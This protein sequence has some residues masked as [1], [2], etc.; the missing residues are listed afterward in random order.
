MTDGRPPLWLDGTSLSARDV[1]AV[2]RTLGPTDV[3]LDRAALAHVARAARLGADLSTRR[4][5]YGRTTGVG[6]NRDEHVGDDA[7]PADSA[8]S[9]GLSGS[10]G[11]TGSAGSA[12]LTGSAGHGLRL[13]RSH[14]GGAGDQLDPELVRAAML[15]RLN[16]LLTG[17]SGVSPGLVHALADAVRTGARPVVH[18]LGAIGTGDLAPLAQI[19][20]ALAGEGAWDTA[21]PVPEPVAVDAG[22][23]LAFV[24]SNAVTLAESALAAGTLDV[25]LASSHVVAALSYLALDGSPEA[26]ADPVHRAR[27][28]PGQ[29]RC[30]QR[31]RHLL[32]MERT[33]PKG[34]RIQ[35]P[36]GLRA[37]PQVNGPAIDAL[38]TLHRVLDVEINA[39]AENPMI[40]VA[41]DDVYHHAHFHTAY[42]AGALDHV[43]A[44]IH[45]VA[46][47]SAARLG[48][49]VE[50][51][52]TGLRAFL[53]DG[54]PGSSGVMILEYMSHDALAALRQVAL[55]VTLGSAVVSRG[56]ED[57]ASF[58]TQAA[59]ATTEVA[60]AYTR[61]LACE[62]VAAVR[63]LRLRRQ[64]AGVPAAGTGPAPVEEAL[65]RAEE[66]LDPRTEDRPLADD[67]AVAVDLLLDPTWALV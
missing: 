48:D 37:F 33:P 31:M 44:C 67:V 13:L 10:A 40:A 22:D 52:Q 63:A 1:A 51:E 27:P 16:Q 47:L 58:S 20:L 66:V 60:I 26:Y 43:R 29:V 3:H 21:P 19:A 7:E 36:F 11:L 15:I 56:L 35:D 54:P 65:A 41:E 8:G 34:R 9:G 12:G 55:P 64:N 18:H 17:R 4:A 61:V 25:V 57:H 28:H 39:G 6:A 59:R 30:A 5:V 2:A 45:G 42:V 53:V 32:G 38:D 49:L 23:A 14:S 24:S 50:P 46:E 62:L